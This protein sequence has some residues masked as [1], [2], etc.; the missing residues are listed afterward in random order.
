MEVSPVR[1][2]AAGLADDSASRDAGTSAACLGSTGD[3]RP[4]ALLHSCPPIGFGATAAAGESFI[5]ASLDSKPVTTQPSTLEC[6]QT[7]CQVAYG[8]SYAGG[9]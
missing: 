1:C 2:G 6:L 4:A 9:I 7:I 5:P 8:V 3:G